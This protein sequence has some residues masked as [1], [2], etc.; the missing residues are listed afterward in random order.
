M[1]CTSSP[2]RKPPQRHRAVTERPQTTPF[3]TILRLTNP[4][5][6]AKYQK[7]HPQRNQ[8]TNS[9]NPDPL[10]QLRTSVSFNV[11]SPPASSPSSSL[12]HMPHP[13]S[14]PS[15]HGSTPCGTTAN[16]SSARSSLSIMISSPKSLQHGCTSVKPSRHCGTLWPH[17]LASTTPR[18]LTGFW[19]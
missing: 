11:K 16:L 8:C 5:S 13:T 9:L 3:L 19:R 17:S 2:H 6:K 15:F 10:Y 4:F 18:S 14:P 12:V 7:Q 1:G